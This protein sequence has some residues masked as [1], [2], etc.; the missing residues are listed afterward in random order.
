MG[1]AL[2]PVHSPLGM[3]P[4]QR[5]DQRL[6]WVSAVIVSATA[7][8]LVSVVLVGATGFEPV[9]SSVSGHARPFARSVAALH[10]TTSALLRRVTE[11]GAAVRREAAY[12]IAADK[13]LTAGRELQ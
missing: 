8:P 12:G 5:T 11:P 10:G 9:T 4:R 13:L 3:G 1:N 6:R 2:H 7:F